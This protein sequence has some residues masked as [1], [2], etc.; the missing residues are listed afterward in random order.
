MGWRFRKSI[1]VCPGV[2]VNLGNAGFT[3]VSAGVRGSSVSVGKRGVRQTISLP[4]SGL[5]HSEVHPYKRAAQVEQS[6]AWVVGVRNM[7]LTVAAVIVTLVVVGLY[8]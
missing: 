8:G 4:G 5:S 7:L 1:R 6:S 3:S 2:R